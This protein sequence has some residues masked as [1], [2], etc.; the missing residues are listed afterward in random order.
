VT[1]KWTHL[2][3][4]V[5]NLVPATTG[6]GFLRRRKEWQREEKCEKNDWCGRIRERLTRRTFVLMLW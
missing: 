5:Q 1:E 6:T 4:K 3:V 2:T